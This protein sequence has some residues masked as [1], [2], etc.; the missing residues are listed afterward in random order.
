MTAVTIGATMSIAAARAMMTDFRVRQLLVRDEG[1]LVGVVGLSDLDRAAAH[2]AVCE[3]MHRDA[4][5]LP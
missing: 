5:L 3:V 2:H 4:K 1:R